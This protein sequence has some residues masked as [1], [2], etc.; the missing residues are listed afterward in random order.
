MI[1]LVVFSIPEVSLASK[2]VTAFSLVAFLTKNVGCYFSMNH[3]ISLTTFSFLLVK[4]L[5]QSCCFL[6]WFN[7]FLGGCFHEEGHHH[8]DYN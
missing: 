5:S 6:L 1:N 8:I 7:N 2:Q 4:D 3:Y